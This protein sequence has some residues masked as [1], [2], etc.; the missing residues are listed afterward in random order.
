M[1]IIGIKT[2]INEYKNIF[3]KFNLNDIKNS[4][5]KIN[6]NSIEG[7]ELKASDFKTLSNIKANEKIS[8][9]FTFIDK[10]TN[11]IIDSRAY[12]RIV[13]GNKKFY[14][15]VRDIDNKKSLYEY[16]IYMIA[17]PGIKKNEEI[18]KKLSKSFYKPI[19]VFKISKISYKL[20]VITLS[21]IFFSICFSYLQIDIRSVL[22]ENYGFV[23]SIIDEFSITSSILQYLYKMVGITSLGIF[24]FSFLT[25]IIILTIDL[26][27]Q[28]LFF[29]YKMFFYRKKEK[30]IESSL[31][32]SFYNFKDNLKLFKNVNFLFKIFMIYI[33]FMITFVFPMIFF[34][35]YNNEKNDIN[36]RYSI[37]KKYLN[38]SAFPS[39]VKIEESCK[40]CKKE[41]LIVGY[42][43]TYTYYYDYSYID[44]LINRQ[45]K[46]INEEEIDKSKKMSFNDIY[47]YLLNNLS[48]EERR[49][50]KNEDYKII[51]KIDIS[52]Y[53][54]KFLFN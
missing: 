4:C 16:D 15:N 2:I 39:L 33:V 18:I 38:M 10:K 27:L 44:K 7:L 37:I 51:D 49:F 43:H 34:V 1:D 5:T 14:L 11:K 48:K 24:V 28:G 42:D 35:T 45:T 8:L 23:D 29:L 3:V 50:I 32:F 54:P 17:I 6:I 19:R 47:A 46:D 52:V 25:V 9:F 22:I 26:I 41:V 31:L 21:I 30:E 13:K 20:K 40:N 53:E 12:S 36:L